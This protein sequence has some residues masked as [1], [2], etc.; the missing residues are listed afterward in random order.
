MIFY[1]VSK[2]NVIQVED[3]VIAVAR[4]EGNVILDVNPLTQTLQCLVKNAKSELSSTTGV[5]LN[6]NEISFEEKYE[7]KRTIF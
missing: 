1:L 2:T 7:V 3:K 4:K 5:L 6:G